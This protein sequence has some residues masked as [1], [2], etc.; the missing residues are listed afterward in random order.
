MTLLTVS[1][2]LAIV[3]SLLTRDFALWSDYEAWLLQEGPWVRVRSLTVNAPGRADVRVGYTSAA[4][5]A[6]EVQRSR[7]WPRRGT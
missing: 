6:Y 1:A 4:A 7:M 5:D 2:V 3:A